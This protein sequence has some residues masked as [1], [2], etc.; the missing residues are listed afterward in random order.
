MEFL[1]Y[2]FQSSAVAALFQQLLCL[3]ALLFLALG[4]VLRGVSLDGTCC[5]Y[6]VAWILVYAPIFHLQYCSLAVSYSVA[7]TVYYYGVK[8]K[9][10]LSLFSVQGASS[11]I[12]MELVSLLGDTRELGPIVHLYILCSAL[13]VLLIVCLENEMDRDAS[14]PML[15][16]Y[17]TN[18]FFHVILLLFAFFGIDQFDFYIIATIA[19]VLLF[20]A[21]F[22]MLMVHLQNFWGEQHKKQE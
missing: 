10:V 2:A 21:R 16:L 18:F 1:Q 11:V 17:L 6:L 5:V 20:L 4:L 12:A 7:A 22:S 8:T 14:V 19:M 15:L 3:K 9:I 13:F